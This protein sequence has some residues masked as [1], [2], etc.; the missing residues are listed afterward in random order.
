L[1]SFPI[2]GRSPYG[3]T[4]I[5]V[6]DHAG[7]FYTGCCDTEIVAFTGE[8]A[9]RGDDAVLCP[10]P[11]DFP[12]C[13]VASCLCGYTNAAGTPFAITGSY[14]GVV[15]AQHLQYDGHAGYDYEAGAGTALVATR[16][17]M[18]CKAIADP[19]NGTAGA[20]TAWDGFHA[21]YIE[22]GTIPRPRRAIDSVALP[23][24]PSRPCSSARARRRAERARAR[25]RHPAGRAR[26]RRPGAAALATAIARPRRA[27]SSRCYCNPP[28]TGPPRS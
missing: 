20:A 19:V 14:S 21:F 9:T 13:L 2:A 26:A 8:H 4:I 23:T 24:A 17:G 15:D 11:P 10:A 1:A 27:A 3:T 7:G 5:A 22:H 28:T 18:L 6:L 25:R 16:D 12:A